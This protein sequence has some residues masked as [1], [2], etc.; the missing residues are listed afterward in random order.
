MLVSVLC[1]G[2]GCVL[3]SGVMYQISDYVYR[4][5]SF[6]C[7]LSLIIVYMWYFSNVFK[8]FTFFSVF[9]MSVVSVTVQKKHRSSL[10]QL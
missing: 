5:M 7:N 1:R 6:M 3:L 2:L 8:Y 9:F 4:Y 10:N